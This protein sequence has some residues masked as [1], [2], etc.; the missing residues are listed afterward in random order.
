[1]S[2]PL[3]GPIV[4]VSPDPT[5]QNSE[6]DDFVR[7]MFRVQFAYLY[8]RLREEPGVGMDQALG[9]WSMA[10]SILNRT[11]G[12]Q[13]ELNDP[14]W[15]RILAIC[16]ETYKEHESRDDRDGFAASLTD[17]LIERLRQGYKK[18]EQEE[19]A[20]SWFGCFRYDYNHDRKAVFLHIRNAVVSHS[21]FEDI[22]ARRREMRAL[23]ED[24]ERKGLEVEQV[25]CGSWINGLKPFQ[26]LFPPGYADSFKISD[27]YSAG[28][29]GWWGQLITKEGRINRRRAQMVHE[30]GRFEYP[31]VDGVCEYA[32]FKKHQGV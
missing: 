14:E 27:P 2:V 5:A 21:P 1:M 30:E 3:V 11:D 16:W 13:V 9:C 4:V 25:C 31:R 17:Q 23:V 29:Y 28:G 6:D 19:I 20:R 32:A 24:I 7:E 12:L 8:R 22:D 10:K 15:R 26:E 18:L